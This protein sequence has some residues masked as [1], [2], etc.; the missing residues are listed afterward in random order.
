MKKKNFDVQNVQE[1]EIIESSA[2]TEETQ[3]QTIAKDEEY[4]D[5]RQLVLLLSEENK[6]LKE[7]KL[8]AKKAIELKAAYTRNEQ[9][10]GTYAVK[11][12]QFYEAL[13]TLKNRPEEDETEKINITIYE[14]NNRIISKIN[15]TKLLVSV[16][17]LMYTTAVTRLQE[18]EDENKNLLQILGEI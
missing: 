15:T 6:Q 8:T 5:L 18:L 9:H 1:A 16:I 11:A 7:S 2:A 14:G 13:E 4:E 17:E 3:L 10:I 12:T